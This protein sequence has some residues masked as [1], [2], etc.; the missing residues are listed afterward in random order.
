MMTKRLEVL[1]MQFRILVSDSLGPAL[2]TS[3]FD[4]FCLCSAERSLPS[5]RY[6]RWFRF[7]S[8]EFSALSD[9]TRVQVHWDH[10]KCQRVALGRFLPKLSDVSSLSSSMT[11]APSSRTGPVER[12][13]GYASD[14]Q[15]PRAFPLAIEPLLP[16]EDRTIGDG[17]DRRRV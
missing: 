3:T 14:T 6:F 1:I 10:V 9:R 7:F 2:P 15:R 13:D 11:S 16:A 12:F 17:M 4:R 8:G 5:F